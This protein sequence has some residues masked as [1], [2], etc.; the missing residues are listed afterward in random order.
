MEG[1][2]LQP[3]VLDELADATE[4]LL[5]YEPE[6][7]DRGI[8]DQFVERLPQYPSET[9]PFDGRYVRH[10]DVIQEALNLQD[11]TAS[12]AIKQFHPVH[13]RA[14]EALQR[15][16]NAQ[17]ASYEEET[18]ALQRAVMNRYDPLLRGSSDPQYEYRHLMQV[19]QMKHDTAMMHLNRHRDAQDHAYARMRNMFEY[20]RNSSTLHI[21]KSLRS[22]QLPDLTPFRAYNFPSQEGTS[23]ALRAA[24]HDHMQHMYNMPTLPDPPAPD[25]SNTI[26]RVD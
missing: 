1:L 16:L 18:R 17:M 11:V 6:F 24:K 10:A 7:P 13:D 25:P 12:E 19:A 5:E 21:L 15:A 22:E 2:T 14:N 20:E 26:E 9:S 23:Q 4:A 3:S 8:Y